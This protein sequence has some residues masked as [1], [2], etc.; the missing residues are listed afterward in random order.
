MLFI[1]DLAEYMGLQDAEKKE[2][3]Y[4]RPTSVGRLARYING[5]DAVITG[6]LHAS[7]IAYSYAVPSVGLVWNDKQRMFGRIIGHPE[8]FIET[9]NFNP[10]TVIDAVET[11]IETGYD[12]EKRRAFTLTTSEFM[13]RF[14]RDYLTDETSTDPLT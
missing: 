5:F 8:R 4:E 6:R 7:I 1:D 2:L 9:E 11:A 12:E 14:I 10:K 13:D 3:I